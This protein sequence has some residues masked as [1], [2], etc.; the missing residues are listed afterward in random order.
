MFNATA[1]RYAA[2]WSTL[3]GRS[4]REVYV[5]QALRAVECGQRVRVLTGRY[6]DQWG[7]VTAI[8]KHGLIVD[9]DVT[10]VR[11]VVGIVAEG[12][13]WARS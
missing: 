5:P 2:H 13:D 7:A 3:T 10:G 6:A 9:L 11:T 1:R 8:G 12:R 4:Q